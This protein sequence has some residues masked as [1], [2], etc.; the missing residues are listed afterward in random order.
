MKVRCTECKAELDPG[1]HMPGDRVKCA[2]CEKIFTVIPEQ[3]RGVECI[4]VCFMFITILCIAGIIMIFNGPVYITAGA[5]IFSMCVFWFS[6]IPPIG[7]VRKHIERNNELMEII[8]KQNTKQERIEAPKNTK[9]NKVFLTTKD[10]KGHEGK[11]EN[12]QCPTRNFQG[13]IEKHG[14]NKERDGV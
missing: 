5:V 2:G 4:E 12:I 6:V 3:V 14:K 11:E 7:M 9:E 8:I 1:E 10:T 13:T